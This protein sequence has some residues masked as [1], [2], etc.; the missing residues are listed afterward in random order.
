MMEE[1]E[2]QPINIIKNNETKENINLKTRKKVKGYCRFLRNVIKEKS[3]TLK[4]I[5]QKRFIKWRKDALKGKIKKTVMIRISVS[6]EKDP[7]SKYQISKANPKEQSKS[8]NKNEL[9]SF[10]I[11]NLPKNITNLKVQKIDDF[12]K[13]DNKINNN[14][15]NDVKTFNNIEIKSI[16][17]VNTNKDKNEKEDK[18][19]IY[20]TGNA[21][22]KNEGNKDN[23]D[24]NN[25]AIKIVLSKNNKKDNNSKNKLNNQNT[26]P[27]INPKLNKLNQENISKIPKPNQNI[28]KNKPQDLN[29]KPISNISNINVV[30]TSSTKKNNPNEIK[31]K[32]QSNY[33]IKN[34]QTDIKEKKNNYK[35]KENQ[36]DL[37]DKIPK[38][39]YRKY[40]GNEQY[41]SKP[42]N[43]IKIDLTKDSHSRQTFNKHINNKSYGDLSYDINKI[44]NTNI[45]NNN[46]YQG[47]NNNKN[48]NGNITN[49]KYSVKTDIYNNNDSSSLHSR[50]R[51]D[52]NAPGNIKIK[53]ISKGGI[54]TV[55]QHYSGQRRKYDNYDNNTHDIN[56][57]KK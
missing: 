24:N 18:N 19:M 15:V 5:I 43:N 6:K 56:K 8:V 39:L 57:N 51:K 50:S 31:N 30:Y 55:I 2:N 46:T 40:E 10:N 1:K 49:N 20:K 17:N 29:K 11:N 47:K 53:K 23:K 14:R 34:Y 45:Y 21:N 37:K 44:Q 3:K 42:V 52:S 16:S 25:N 33:P 12:I 32:V 27:I 38:V 48:N 7:K 28:I 35:A 22:N 9:K 36:T 26:T 13:E 41:N 4:Q 54:T